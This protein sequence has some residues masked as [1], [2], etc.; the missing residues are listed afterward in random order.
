MIQ[1]ISNLIQ[2]NS[3]AH[4][5]LGQIEWEI[6]EE[7]CHK[8]CLLGN[9]VT[10]AM[11]RCLNRENLF[12]VN[13]D[14]HGSFSHLPIISIWHADGLTSEQRMK[15]PGTIFCQILYMIKN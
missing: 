15:I 13:H 6:L 10:D 9:I 1:S 4:N 5:I 11:S 8:Q 3:T 12:Q 7:S 2:R 14:I